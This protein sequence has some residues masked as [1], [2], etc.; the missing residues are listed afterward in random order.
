MIVDLLRNDLGRLAEPG[1]VKVD[2]LFE[3]EDYPTVWQM[4]SEVS[5]RIGRQGFESVLRAL[6]L[7]DRLPAHRKFAPCRSSERWKGTASLHRGALGWLALMET[8]G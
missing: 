1:S 8:S 4:V 3:I 6:F 5:A 2:R 7:A